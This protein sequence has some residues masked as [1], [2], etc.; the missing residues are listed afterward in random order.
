M[1]SVF[2]LETGRTAV[3]RCRG[4][5]SKIGYN[6]GMFIP[7]TVQEIKTLGWDQPDIILV[8]GDAYI[9]S[10]HIGV[11]V[12]GK[13]LLQH[14]FRTAIIAQPSTADGHD[15]TR[16]GEPK[17]FW[18]VT[19]GCVD[20]M[21]ANYTSSKKRRRQDDYTPGGVNIRPDRA[22]ITYAN[23]IR[24]SRQE[25]KTRCPGRDRGKS[26]PDRA[27]RLLGRRPAALHPLRRE[28]RHSRLRH[29]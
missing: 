7:T 21:V 11:A 5:V 20:S 18:G 8:T 13:Y 6:T 24:Q 17:L 16:L 10:P 4:K 29:G 1:P 26:S 23:L 27:L 28:S 14:G 3:I 19:G 15:I 25:Q 9:D 2:P 12:I 22:T